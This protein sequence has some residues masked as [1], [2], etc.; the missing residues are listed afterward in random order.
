MVE[1]PNKPGYVCGNVI[2]GRASY[3]CSHQGANKK[4]SPIWGAKTKP[5]REYNTECLT[6]INDEL[7]GNATR[8]GRLLCPT[9]EAIKFGHTQTGV[10]VRDEIPPWVNR[11]I[12]AFLYYEGG[13][14]TCDVAEMCGKTAGWTRFVRTAF[15][16]IDWNYWPMGGPSKARQLARKTHAK[17]N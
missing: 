3:C 5:H 4:G 11:N 6:L 13:A 10:R 14:T 2:N 16:D 1:D 9:C 12:I 17:K 8:S 7:C 15:P